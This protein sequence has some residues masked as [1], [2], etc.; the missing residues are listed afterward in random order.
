MGSFRL[1]IVEDNPVIRDLFMLGI[2]RLNEELAPRDLH[3][4]VLQAEDGATAWEQIIKG[5]IDLLVSDLYIPVLNGLDLIHRVRNNPATATMKILAISASIQDARD[6][7]LGA[8]ADQFL[9][10][11]LRLLDLLDALKSLLHLP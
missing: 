9:Q 6:R 4:E 7:A 5:G 1:L 8:G 2:A 10:K 11:P 3:L